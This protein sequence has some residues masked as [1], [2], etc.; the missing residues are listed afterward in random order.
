MTTDKLS[1]QALVEICF[2]QGI[3][4]VIFSPGSRNAPL[5]IGFSEHGGFDTLVIADER[6]AAFHA[7][8]QAIA[9]R[10][11]SIICCT[12]G[13]AA[14]NYGPAIAEAYYQKVPMLI[15]TADRPVEWIDMG[16]GQSMSCLL[17]TSPSP[18]DS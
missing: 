8:G 18:R 1:V 11:P 4:R 14:L 6:V 15:L 17:Y 7:L 9:T 13:T 10:V 3:R 16:I 2:K 5:V 12:S